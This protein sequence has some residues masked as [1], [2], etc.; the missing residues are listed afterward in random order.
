M[1]LE[2]NVHNLPDCLCEMT[3][4]PFGTWQLLGWCPNGTFLSTT[5]PKIFFIIFSWDW[6]CD[7][8]EICR[9]CFSWLGFD[10]PHAMGRFGNGDSCQVVSCAFHSTWSRDREVDDFH[11]HTYSK[12]T[13]PFITTRGYH[14]VSWTCHISLEKPFIIHTD[15]FASKMM[16]KAGL[17]K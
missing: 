11:F 13:H 2:S 15:H 4:P 17:I 7:I 5:I 3:Q 12:D 16:Y 10:A 8:Q 9:M 6:L 14:Q 1:S